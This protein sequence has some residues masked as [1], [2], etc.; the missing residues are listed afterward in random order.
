MGG[1]IR[2]LVVDDHTAVRIGLGG[3]LED[4]SDIEVVATAASAREALADAARVAP[5]VAVVD[6]HLGDGD[7]LTL[8]RAMK[9]LPRPPRV[10]VYSAYAD[11]PLTAAAVV[12]G[13]DAVLS[14]GTLGEE[15]VR[16]IRT[17]AHGRRAIPPIPR[18]VLRSLRARLEP[19]DQSILG[20]LIQGITPSE[21]ASVLRI[22]Q[23]RLESR[24]AA[25]VHA[26]MAVT[27]NGSSREPALTWG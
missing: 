11:G 4:R 10:L 6:F 15:V 20:M 25:I 21:V 2:V 19:A 22:S 18:A 14:K 12:A 7:G 5:D 17:L 23:S 26:L 9:R 16:T 1:A 3:L 8:C 24:R 13:A 27:P